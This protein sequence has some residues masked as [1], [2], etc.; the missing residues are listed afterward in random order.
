MRRKR[1]LVSKLI[2]FSQ[3]RQQI[4]VV[5]KITLVSKVSL[6]INSP[7]CFSLFCSLCL[8]S[9]RLLK[10]TRHFHKSIEK[11]WKTKQRLLPA[12]CRV[13]SDLPWVFCTLNFLMSKHWFYLWPLWGE[14]IFSSNLFNGGFLI[15]AVAVWLWRCG[16]KIFC[17]IKY[18]VIV[19]ILE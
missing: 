3:L 4:T 5:I 12:A 2:T 16:H 7:Y 17:S 9:F 18:M 15:W 14:I 1:C 11:S 10:I 8:D 13:G 19:K 6:Q